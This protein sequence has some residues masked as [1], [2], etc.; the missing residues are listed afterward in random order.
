MACVP[1][2]NWVYENSCL[3]VLFKELLYNR[4][5]ELTANINSRQTYWL[6]MSE[7]WAGVANDIFQ[8]G[9]KKERKKKKLL[10]KFK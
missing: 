9:K 4:E 3:L 1:H 6:M 5:Q 8:E 2:L 10:F 7:R